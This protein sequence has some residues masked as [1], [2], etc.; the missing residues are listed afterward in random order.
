[1]RWLKRLA[2]DGA[3]RKYSL[4][5][6][7]S[8]LLMAA[9]VEP[10]LAG[11]P[12]GGIIS[13]LKIGAL[14]H[15]PGDLWSGFRREPESIDIN[16][17]ALLAPSV[18]FLGGRI[19]PAIGGSIN[20][21]GGTS[22]GYIDARWEIETPSGIFFALGLGAAI[23]DGNIDPIDPSKKALGS[24]VL[25]HI[26]AEIGWRF[27][28]HNSVSVYFEHISNGYTQESNEGLDSLGAR[29]GYKF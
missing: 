10:G 13:E 5:V 24:R 23:H 8:A 17:E 6:L 2:G 18:A 11:E 25:F 19:R 28:G 29:Y 9:G 7:L 15:D 1:M 22:K 14:W 27:D 4:I 16:I 26:P 12:L 21:D 3:L 20:T